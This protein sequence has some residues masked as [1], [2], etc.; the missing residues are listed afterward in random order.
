MIHYRYKKPEIL[1]VGINPHPGSFHRRVPFSNNK[2]FWYLLSEAGLIEEKRDELRDD[3]VLKHVY[4]D[5]FNAAYGLGFVNLI[6]RP[7]R[8]ITEIKKHEELPGRKKICGIISAEMPKVVCFI[9]KV[10]YEKYTGSKDF[11]FGWQESIGVSRV[12]VMHFPLR[13]EASIRVQELRK[14]KRAL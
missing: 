8:D 14:V 1:F 12:F 3:K 2:L 13:G 5:K 11:S 6:D 9:G 7:T 4:K 10:A